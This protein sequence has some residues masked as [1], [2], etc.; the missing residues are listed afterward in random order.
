MSM[1]RAHRRAP[2]PRSLTVCR[3][4]RSPGIAILPRGGR[5]TPSSRRD[6]G[7][8]RRRVRWSL[9]W[10]VI[11]FFLHAYLTRAQGGDASLCPENSIG[12]DQC[13]SILTLTRQD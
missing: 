11:C 3:A 4:D 1:G 6:C 5:G 12:G 13:R 9:P 2:C 7:E 10:H 8:L